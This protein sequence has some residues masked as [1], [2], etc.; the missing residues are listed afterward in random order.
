MPTKILTR[1]CKIW[2]GC[3]HKGYGRTRRNGRSVYLHRWTYEQANGQL[4]PSIFVCHH[5]DN[6]VCYELEHLFAGTAKDNTQDAAAK[7]RLAYGIKHGR[8]KITDAEV[9]AIRADPRSSR[10]I[11]QDYPISK[12]MISYIKS[13]ENWQH[14]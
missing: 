4:P 1:P 9:R 12:S 14:L 11:A 10:A 2:H 13:G 3:T 6:P 5:C 7:N 8:A